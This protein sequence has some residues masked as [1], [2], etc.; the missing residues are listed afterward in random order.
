M[1]NKKPVRLKATV[2]DPFAGWEEESTDRAR[3]QFYQ[4]EPPTR[5]DEIKY[6]S[7]LEEEKEKARLRARN[8][9]TQPIVW[10][11]SQRNLAEW[12]VNSYHAGEL[13]A[14]S[15]QDV[16]RQLCQHFV[17]ADGKPFNPESIRVNISN[18]RLE[19]RGKRKKINIT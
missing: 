6:A 10:K 8:T 3:S 17:G 11:G 14:Q 5:L 4:P 12:L 15:E 2:P 18:R 1:T 9:I 13:D 7:L 16:Y 19:V